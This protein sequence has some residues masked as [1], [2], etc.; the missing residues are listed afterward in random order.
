MGD[1][2]DDDD[3][4]EEEEE[5][6]D[7][8]Y[9]EE[10]EELVAEFRGLVEASPELLKEKNEETGDTLLHIAVYI[11]EPQ[12]VRA[13]LAFPNLA[14]N[15]LNS[16]GQSSLDVAV[17][18]YTD[19]S[20]RRGFDPKALRRRR[21]RA[22]KMGFVLQML[23]AHP[24]V[25]VN[26][27]DPRGKTALHNAC[28]RSK[29]RAVKALLKYVNKTLNIN[30]RDQKG[31]T[32]LHY[33]VKGRFY[34]A[35][36]SS[37]SG[38]SRRR[39]VGGE[40]EGEEEDEEE[41]KEQKG[42]A[43]RAAKDLG[44]DL[45]IV[46][47]LLEGGIDV[48]AKDK[49]GVTALHIAARHTDPTGTAITDLLAEYE[50]NN[51]HKRP[52]DDKEEE[53]SRARSNTGS[54]KLSLN[55][56]SLIPGSS[57]RK[58]RANSSNSNDSGVSDVSDL[59][60]ASN[61]CGPTSSLAFTVKLKGKL[62]R[63]KSALKRRSGSRR[64]LTRTNSSSSNSSQR[65]LTELAKRQSQRLKMLAATRFQAFFS[66]HPT[67][68]AVTKRVRRVAHKLELKVYMNTDTLEEASEK[69]SKGKLLVV[70]LDVNH[71]SECVQNSPV[72]VFFVTRAY[73]EA[74]ADEKND[75]YVK[76]QFSAARQQSKQCIA[77]VLEREMMD[78]SEWFGPL[79]AWLDNSSADKVVD[80]SKGITDGPLDLLEQEIKASSS[81]SSS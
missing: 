53:E 40:E 76:T 46:T 12:F 74:V 36:K 14:V 45:Q 66:H 80:M 35:R 10:D 5:E 51:E 7:V 19:C 58:Q 62:A 63:K 6:E 71:I 4:E 8:E 15:A 17:R 37:R 11:G 69:A 25:D 2:D 68:D 73:M 75:S 65:D 81:S 39:G 61:E 42:E 21:A 79:K 56:S 9:D 64:N 47:L 3:E 23:L 43:R 78:F 22:R 38:R 54:R 49:N 20:R 24:L 55:L 34:V 72:F 70:P 26:L 32:A 27:V 77:V 28:A 57:A 52:V 31:R 13:L 60:D 30:V 59:S 50:K 29:Y 18:R 67:S 44:Y 1:V 16:K 33:A 41:E 48:F